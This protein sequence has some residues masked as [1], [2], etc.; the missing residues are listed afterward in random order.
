MIFGDLLGHELLSRLL[1]GKYRV[2]PRES[3]I[4]GRVKENIYFSLFF[5]CFD[6][7][8][9]NTGSGSGH[10]DIGTT[11]FLPKN[12]G[13]SNLQ[14]FISS[15]SSLQLSTFSGRGEGFCRWVEAYKVTGESARL[16]KMGAMHVVIYQINYFLGNQR[17]GAIRR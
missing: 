1:W 5:L 13:T 10:Q 7:V 2:R 8:P 14:D 6:T 17:E 15:G 12:C 11:E 3:S 16:W 4:S 9:S